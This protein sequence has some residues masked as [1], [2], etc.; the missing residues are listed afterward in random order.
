MRT[1]NGDFLTAKKGKTGRP[2]NYM[3]LPQYKLKNKGV[4][5]TL[6]LEYP[7]VPRPFLNCLCVG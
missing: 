4:G 3:S 2:I 7:R 1:Q 6:T 5:A